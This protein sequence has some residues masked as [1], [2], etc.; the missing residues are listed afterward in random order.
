MELRGER[1]YASKKRV[2]YK[3]WLHN[4][5][6]SSL[7]SRYAEE[8]KSEALMMK[9]SKM[10]YWENFGHKLKAFWQT[11]QCLRDKASNIARSIK[12]QNGVL[13]RNVK[14]ILGSCR[15]HFK[16]ILNPITITHTR[17]IWG[18]NYQHCSRSIPCCQNTVGCDEIRPE[19]LKALEQAVPWPTR[20]FHVAWCSGGGPKDWRQTVVI[21]PIHKKELGGN[22]QLHGRLSLSLASLKKCRK[23]MPRN[24]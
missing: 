16:D 23:K 3:A 11:I 22:T 18:G 6:D 15:D 13:L 9:K 2:A 4:K 21:I 20:V 24:N 12:D 10:Q 19:I 1:C 5:A 8:G 7:H 14:S 17:Y